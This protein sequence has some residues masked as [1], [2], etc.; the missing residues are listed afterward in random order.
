MALFSSC[1]GLQSL[2]HARVKSAM[3]E[4]IEPGHPVEDITGGTAYEEKAKP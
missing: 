1:I 3:G 2:P 4:D